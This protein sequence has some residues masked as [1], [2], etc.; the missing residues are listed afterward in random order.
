MNLEHLQISHLNDM[1]RAEFVSHVGWI[2]EH[3]PWVAERAWEYRPFTTVD[4]LHAA[5]DNVVG[6][7]SPEEKMSLI[8]AHPDLGGRLAQE[9]NLTAASTREQAIAGMNALIPAEAR[10]MT[11]NNA[12]Y[13]EKFGFPFIVCVRL[14]NIG[15]IRE[16]FAD[17][18]QNGRAQEINVALGE[19]SKIAR[20]RLADFVA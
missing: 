1:D 12:L 19:I 17:R 4:S 9:R 5:M 6:S 13:R 2:Y 10:E 16:A 20:L 18:L 8:E 11:T 15:L 3:S 7:A 14:N